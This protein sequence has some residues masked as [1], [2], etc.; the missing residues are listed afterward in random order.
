MPNAPHCAAP[1][2][3]G[4]FSLMHATLVGAVMIFGGALYLGLALNR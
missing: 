1:S 4:R 2:S 3:S